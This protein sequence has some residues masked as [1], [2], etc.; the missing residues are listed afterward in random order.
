MKIGDFD[1]DQRVLIVAEIGN[2]H[3]GDFEVAQKMVEE[4]ANCGVDAVKFQTFKT[5]HYVN[6]ADTARFERLKSFELTYSE[7][8]ELS[9]LARSQGLIFVSTPFDLASAS[10]LSSIVDAYKIASGDNTF[11]PLMER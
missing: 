5:E 7:F 2:N 6:R 9:T 1:L 8:E 4:A 3:E 11:Y 10:F